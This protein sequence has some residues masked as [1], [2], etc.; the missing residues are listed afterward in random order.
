MVKNLLKNTFLP[1]LCNLLLIKNCKL[2]AHY[3]KDNFNVEHMLYYLDKFCYDFS[4]K[5][6]V[7]KA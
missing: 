5:E 3:K 6:M 4:K 7:K 2:Y 1:I